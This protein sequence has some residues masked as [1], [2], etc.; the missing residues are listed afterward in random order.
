MSDGDGMT[1][2]SF[3]HTPSVGASVHYVSEGSPPL[4][5]GSQKYPSVCRAAIVTEVPDVQIP[6][7]NLASL[8]VVNPTGLFF[9][10]DVEYGEK[11]VPGTWHWP[12]RV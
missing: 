5:D 12:E 2:S 1:N 11:V 3:A 6:E 4:P 10:A 8:C 9:R 7:G